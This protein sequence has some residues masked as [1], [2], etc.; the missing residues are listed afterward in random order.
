MRVLE[1]ELEG[2]RALET[3]RIELPGGTSLFTGANAQG[4]TSV[5]EAVYLLTGAPSFRTRHDRELIRFDGEAARISALVM[6]G[7]REQR[8]ELLYRRGL[9]RR[10]RRN[11]L[12]TT[13]TELGETMRAVF[14]GPEE[15]Q[16][17]RGGP[18][19][20]RQLIDRAI[21]QLRPGYGKRMEEYR[22]ILEQKRAILKNWREK[23]SLLEPLEEYSSALCA[24]SAHI[25][26][27]RGSYVRRLAQEAGRIHAGFTGGREKLCLRYRSE[28]GGEDPEAPV[29]EIYAR[30]ME[31]QRELRRAELESGMALIGA[32]RDELDIE[33]SDSPARVY[34]SQGQARTAAVSLKLAER[35]ILEAETGESPVLLLDDVLSEL[36]AE[37]RHYILNRLDGGQ[38]LVTSCG[39]H[40][41]APALYRVRAGRV[42]RQEEEDGSVPG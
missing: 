2:F 29:R 27:A 14:F 32:H 42:T 6:S 8:I 36:D 23:R 26:R 28:G 10:I 11:G 19:P 38:V 39:E 37:R 22:R 13:G 31:R 34:A 15:L 33:L 3:Q 17:V 21:A 25:I 9:A 20:R 4:K 12:R 7:G 40:S 18:G 1:L 24:A 5:L 16:L 35:D 30:L 41:W